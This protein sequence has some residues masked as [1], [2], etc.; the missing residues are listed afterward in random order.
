[1]LEW[2][3]IG[4]KYG[5]WGFTGLN[6]NPL[7][8][9]KW[10]GVWQWWTPIKDQADV[11]N[12]GGLTPNIGSFSQSWADSL[13]W[14]GSWHFSTT[15]NYLDRR[16]EDLKRN[17]T[18]PEI[19]NNRGFWDFEVSEPEQQP[20]QKQE[21]PV[22]MSLSEFWQYIKNKY[23]QYENI[24]DEE[25]WQKMLE[26]YPEYSNMVDLSIWLGSKP[27]TVWGIRWQIMELWQQAADMGALERLNPVWKIASTVNEVVNNIPTMTTEDWDKFAKEK[28]WWF[29]EGMGAIPTMVVNAIPSFL[30]TISAI[31]SA[32]LNPVDTMVWLYTLVWTKEGHNVLWDRYGW[33]EQLSKTMTEDPV[34]LASDILTIVSGGAGIAWKWARI[35]WFADTWA[36]LSKFSKT[37]MWTSNVWADVWIAKWWKAL[38]WVADKWW[39]AG[40]IAETA[41]I[42]ATP[43]DLWKTIW[44]LKE[45]WKA[46]ISTIWKWI[47]LFKEQVKWLSKQQQKAIENNPY[48][49]EM[50]AEVLKSVDEWT[51]PH[52]LNEV[53][54]PHLKKLV[55]EIDAVLDEKKKLVS[56][57][58]EG[59]NALRK[60]PTKYDT[61]WLIKEIDAMLEGTTYTAESFL[62]M[63]DEGN[64]LK[65]WDILN[66]EGTTA[67]LHD[68][69]KG[70]D[71][72]LK[73]SSFEK[74]QGRVNMLNKIRKLVDEKLKEN[75]DWKSLDE[76]YSK[77]RN[78]I[79][80]IE[81]WI[82]YKEKRRQ[83]QFRD[84]VDN[85]IA[86]INNPAKANLKARL[87]EYFPD[88]SERVA[89]IQM[90]PEIAKTY[91]KV[92]KTKWQQIV[93]TWLWW[94]IGGWIW[95]L[96]WAIAWWVLWLLTDLAM[97]KARKTAVKNAVNKMSPEAKTKLNIINE[98]ISQNQKLN[99]EQMSIVKNLVDK[100]KQEAWLDTEFNNAINKAVDWL[101]TK[102]SE[103]LSNLNP[104][105]SVF[106]EYTPEARATAPLWKN[107]TT[108][109]DTMWKSP[110]ETITIYRGVSTEGWN[111]VPWDYITTNKQLAQDY[112]WNGKV[113]SKKVRLRDILDDITEPLGEEYIY[114]PKAWVETPTEWLG[115]L[116][117]TTKA[118]TNKVYQGWEWT[119]RKSAD[120]KLWEG[121]YFW[122][123]KQAWEFGN[124]VSEVSLKDKNYKFY[125]PKDTQTYQVE[126]SKHWWKTEFNNYLKE[127][128]YDWIKAMNKAFGEPEY[129]LFEKPA[130]WL[131]NLWK[132]EKQ[133]TPKLKSLQ[134]LQEAA[135]LVKQ[136]QINKNR[137]SI[138][139]DYFNKNWTN[140]VKEIKEGWW[141]TFSLNEM[142]DM[143]WQPYIALSPYPNR[144]HILNIKNFKSANLYEY[145]L[146]NSDKLLE[147]WHTLGVWIDWNA[148]YL[149]TTIVVPKKHINKA[150]E[151]WTKYNQKAI[152]DLETFQEIPTHWDWQPIRINE[153]EVL[154]DIKW[155]FDEAPKPKNEWLSNLGKTTKPKQTD[156]KTPTE[157]TI[158][159]SK[160][161]R[162]FV[163]NNKNSFESAKIELDWFM[164]TLANQFNWKAIKTPLKFLNADWSI[165]VAGI[166]RM[167]QKFDA[168]W[169]DWLNDTVRWTV[170]VKNMKDIG[171]IT[172]E[173][174]NK[175]MVLDN[176]FAAPTELWYRDI[177]TMYQTKNWVMAEMQVNVPEMIV[178][179]DWLAA[180]D[181]WLITKKQYNEIVGK[182]WVEWWLWHKYYEQWRTLQKSL[183]KFE[184]SKAIE[185]LKEITKI[186]K[187]SRKYYEK[188][189]S[190]I[191]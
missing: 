142:R 88:L 85:I 96:P 123:E 40:K 42:I 84:N 162:N 58:W 43:S 47:E 62:K 135:N 116:W 22:K 69:R 151:L 3:N 52:N 19:D 106:A 133:S 161:M 37:A 125:E 31:G 41:K 157:K 51:A 181:M 67:Q 78:E 100:I 4:W 17:E 169:I 54:E 120:G 23:P 172:N 36:R 38:E 44:T 176:K 131:S 129:L 137:V 6:A 72:L 60:D 32:M 147:P 170:L 150:T 185:I 80:Q 189:I 109:A 33:I 191:R 91:S 166:E 115:N 164:D 140:L 187:K 119:I 144:S 103:P 118:E 55:E 27:G 12:V 132:I 121:Y 77:I 7:L 93:T 81:E 74:N 175:N 101:E 53:R 167:F 111:I 128:W 174:S 149:D 163:E 87:A 39:K 104:T 34:W 186:E 57:N 26:K 82:T 178:A 16:I 184:W 148:V 73:K 114:R 46:A 160:D 28:L 134:E 35:A 159:D 99:A 63:V 30:K 143:W 83:W 127:Q 154:R 61:K 139:R 24:S 92:P 71:S 179:K 11:W 66:G 136:E 89:A 15:G 141:A 180:V 190:L 168:K 68:V 165:R 48:V 152:F 188:F 130:E 146:Q 5:T 145:I 25:L 45:G 155:M 9:Q 171:K 14:A 49:K 94:A 56:E 112:A 29:G 156:Y 183:D 2:L 10:T 65:T 18:M 20:E 153:A 122:W 177:S 102:A 90:L 21:L 158:K 138:V 107:I 75:W 98:K 173:L 95:W 108:L 105:N 59:Y 13:Y 124:I 110:N 70:I 64:L 79:S 97:T 86:N 117:K 113:V 1:M 182:A 8:G 76:N 126:A 50:W